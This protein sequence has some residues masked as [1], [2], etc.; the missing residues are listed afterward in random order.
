MKFTDNQEMNTQEFQNLKV[1]E[2]FEDC[3][4]V[5]FI[6]VDNDSAFD[7]C[8]DHLINFPKDEKVYP[9]EAEIIFH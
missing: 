3:E 1:G 7:I 5:L 6:K 8:N 9:R 4:E 2:C